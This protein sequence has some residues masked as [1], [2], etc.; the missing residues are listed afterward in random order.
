MNRGGKDWTAYKK[1]GALDR[2]KTVKAFIQ[3]TRFLGREEFQRRKNT[4]HQ[5]EKNAILTE[6]SANRQLLA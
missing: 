6:K 4:T 2:V 3:V 1:V 5:A